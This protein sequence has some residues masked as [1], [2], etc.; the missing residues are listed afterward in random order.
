MFD[1]EENAGTA[2][3][4]TR[5]DV[6]SARHERPHKECAVT[7]TNIFLSILGCRFS[8]AHILSPSSVLFAQLDV[9]RVQFSLQLPLHDNIIAALWVIGQ[10]RASFACI[11]SSALP[12]S[13]LDDSAVLED[14]HES[15]SSYLYN[16]A[17]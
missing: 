14:Y 9:H 11:C 3:L 8:Q 10:P 13:F 16:K 5:A 12:G 4:W 17:N 7:E 2:H 1:L 15:F 6:K